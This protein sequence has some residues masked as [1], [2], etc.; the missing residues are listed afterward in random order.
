MFG[1]LFGKKKGKGDI[2][3]VNS[4][5]FVLSPKCS[6]CG[7]PI[8]MML[9][10]EIRR[11]GF[12]KSWDPVALGSPIYNCTICPACGSAFCL[13]CQRP[14]PDPCPKCGLRKLLPGVIDFVDEYYKG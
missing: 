10:E 1:N 2:S 3:S 6:I 8:S 14:S 12:T 13:N 11:S 5:K 7:E 4:A 9:P